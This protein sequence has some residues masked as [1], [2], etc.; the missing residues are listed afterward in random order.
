[1]NKINI[2]IKPYGLLFLFQMSQGSHL[3]YLHIP[4]VP[5]DT[6]KLSRLSQPTKHFNAF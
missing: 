5:F 3:E 2:F 4:F 1:M 6:A